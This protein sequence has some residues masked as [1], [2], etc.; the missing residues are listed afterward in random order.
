MNQ[1]RTLLNF[2][3]FSMISIQSPNKISSDY[4]IK[5]TKKQAKKLDEK[6]EEVK[7]EQQPISEKQ[8]EKK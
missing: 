5:K 4:F 2:K 6:K 3:E 7:T 8:Q 1:Q